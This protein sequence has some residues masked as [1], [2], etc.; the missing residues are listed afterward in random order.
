M[1]LDMDKVATDEGL[2]ILILK[3]VS[4]SSPILFYSKWSNWTRI[5]VKVRVGT[6]RD[7]TLE[8][9]EELK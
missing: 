6:S 3:T 2:H 4:F 7:I 1:S 9:T 8:E 5:S